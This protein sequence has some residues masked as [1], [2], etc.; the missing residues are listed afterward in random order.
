MILPAK[1]EGLP[2]V[3]EKMGKVKE[4]KAIQTAWGQDNY[5]E[6]GKQILE[7]KLTNF[8]NMKKLCIGLIRED[9]NFAGRV[10]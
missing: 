8:F 10:L 9:Q 2:T 1:T 5:V 4:Y 7:H 6:A 3:I